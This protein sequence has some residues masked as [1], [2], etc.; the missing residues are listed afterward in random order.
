M[1]T[2]KAIKFGVLSLSAA[3]LLAACDDNDTLDTSPADDTE[4]NDDAVDDATIDEGMED[5]EGDAPDDTSDDAVDDATVDEGM[6]DTTEDT[7]GDAADSRGLEGMTF[8]VSLDDAI[9]L[10]YE[11]FGSEDINIEEIQ[12][13]RDNG[14]FVY[15][16][17]GWDGQ[18]EYELDIDAETGEIVKQEQDEDDDS[19][20][21]LDLDGI[22]TPQEA[23]DAALEASGSGY[24]EEWTLEVE[25]GR[26]VYDIDIEDG[27]DQ[28]IDAQTGDVL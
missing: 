4:L 26:T 23:M 10:F 28:E 8:S 24:V 5:P 17:D 6:E 16:M 1:L 22:I 7:S 2:N 20:D 25:D 27:D 12:F 21:V 19:D 11:T 9:D 15:E 14:R 13:D 3:L 18:Y